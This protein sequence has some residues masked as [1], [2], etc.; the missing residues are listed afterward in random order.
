MKI[1]YGVQA[2]GQGHIS[3]ARA[4]AQALNDMDVDIQRSI[5]SGKAADSLVSGKQICACKQVGELTII[6]A[7]ENQNCTTVDAVGKYTQAG[8]GCGSCI[9]EIK[10]LLL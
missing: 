9:P 6:D 3:R 7:I 5:L 2:T 10:Q 1:L 4:M 8:T